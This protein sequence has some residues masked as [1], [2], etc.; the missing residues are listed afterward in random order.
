MVR[1][2]AA[3]VSGNSWLEKGEEMAKTKDMVCRRGFGKPV[4][5]NVW[6]RLRWWLLKLVSADG[7]GR[8]FTS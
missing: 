1:L 5:L 8:R 2:T 7:A 3:C 6:A 4:L